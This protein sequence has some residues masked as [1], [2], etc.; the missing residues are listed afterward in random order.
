[1]IMLHRL[2]TTRFTRFKNLNL[3]SLLTSECSDLF[4]ISV[5]NKCLTSLCFCCVSASCGRTCEDEVSCCV[6]YSQIRTWRKQTTTNKQQCVDLFWFHQALQVT[7]LSSRPLE[8]ATQLK[9]NQL[10]LKGLEG[11]SGWCD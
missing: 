6:H 2:W 9:R 4:C 5:I 1:M 7:K 8:G 3:K 11:K 10:K